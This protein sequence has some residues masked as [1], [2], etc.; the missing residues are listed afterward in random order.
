MLNLAWGGFSNGGAA[1]KAVCVQAVGGI[2]GDLLEPTTANA[3]AGWR[4]A[5]AARTGVWLTLDHSDIIAPGF[6]DIPNQQAAWDRYQRQGRP[7]ASAPGYSNH[8]WARAIDVTGYENRADVW[9]AMNDLAPQ[10]GLSHV[11]GAASGERWHWES[12]GTPSTTATAGGNATPIN[13][14]PTTE[15]DDMFSDAD[16]AQLNAIN[17]NANAAMS[18]VTEVK[19]SLAA[20]RPPAGK[21]SILTTTAASGGQ[22]WALWGP[23]LWVDIWTQDA[24]NGLSLTYG[25]QI[26]VNAQEWANLKAAATTSDQD[27]DTIV[28]LALTLPTGKKWALSAPDRKLWVELWTQDAANGFSVRYGAEVTVVQAEWDGFKTASGAQ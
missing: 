5:I 4:T 13:N 22:S 12:T 24:A 21:P 27:T 2:N 3:W 9:Q 18:G 10:F 26:A 6:R 19:A 20:I 23:G 17:I 11:T 7:I 1:L 25:R 8:G 15:V 16:R 28:L 14:T